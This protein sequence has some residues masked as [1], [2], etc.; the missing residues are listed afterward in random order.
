MLFDTE[1]HDQEEKPSA[2]AGQR[3][4]GDIEMPSTMKLV[5]VIDLVATGRCVLWVTDGDWSM[6]DMLMAILDRTGPA[7]VYLSSY[8]FS[9]FPARLIADM[10]SRG[11]IR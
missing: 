6:H 1:Q 11:I 3:F 2:G 10:K 9:E 7:N 4:D 8:A 5:E